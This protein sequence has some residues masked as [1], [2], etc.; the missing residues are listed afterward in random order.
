MKFF[1]KFFLTAAHITTIIFRGRRKERIRMPTTLRR[2]P[3]QAGNLIAASVA[4]ASELSSK[5]QVAA[6]RVALNMP[7]SKFARLVGRTE[8]AV[9]DWESGRSDPQGLSRQRILELQRLTDALCGLFNIKRLGQWFDTPNPAFS[10]LKPIEVI[11]RGETDRLWQMI[12][13]LR[14]G[15]HV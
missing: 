7:R 1:V 14:A 4:K 5:K 12:F 6:L 8:R 2:R 13:E 10:G 11:E 3:R 9:I 15:T